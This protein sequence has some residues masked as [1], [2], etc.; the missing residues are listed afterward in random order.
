MIFYKSVYMNIKIK[1]E[2]Q[3]LY[4]KVLNNKLL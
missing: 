3:I 2:K 4:N 1:I